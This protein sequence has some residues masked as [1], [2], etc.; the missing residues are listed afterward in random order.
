MS[1]LWFYELRTYHFDS[2]AQRSRFDAFLKNAAIPAYSRMGVEPVGV[3]T[4][5]YGPDSATT[6]VL[7][8]HEDAESVVSSTDRLLED[9]EFL[10]AGRP[11]L[12]T[13]LDHP[14]YARFESTCLRAFPEMPEPELPEDNRSRS[15]RI[16]EMRTYESHSV[17][18]AKKKIEM[19][20]EGGEID[21][22]RRTGL[23]PVLFGET[24]VGP[25]MPSLTYMLTFDD[26][27]MRDEAWETFR[28]D[29]EWKSLSAD[30]QYADTVSTIR[31]IIL[32]PTPY[33]P[34]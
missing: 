18:A 4:G 19:F 22:F 5:V 21:I 10:D 14:T 28:N 2:T 11:F 34:V 12:E 20:N 3:F 9:D 13:D 7:L 23:T 31:D 29:S 25:R 26:M 8:P 32:K 30:P 6:F 1:K 17:P 16:F 33:S 24:V 15:S 27:R